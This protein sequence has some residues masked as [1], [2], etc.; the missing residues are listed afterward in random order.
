VLIEASGAKPIIESGFVFVVHATV[1]FWVDVVRLYSLVSGRYTIGGSR[2]PPMRIA[3][4]FINALV[5]EPSFLALILL[6]VLVNIV[7]SFLAA[8]FYHKSRGAPDKKGHKERQRGLK[9]VT[10][11]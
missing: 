8:S 9:A 4:R 11:R 6:E 7:L 5:I 3:S 10:K 2:P 1:Q